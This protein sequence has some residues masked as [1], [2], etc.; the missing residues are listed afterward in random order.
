M[1]S[2]EQIKAAISLLPEG[3]FLV[4]TSWIEVYEQDRRRRLPSALSP[5]VYERYP[6]YR[7]LPTDYRAEDFQKPNQINRFPA[8]SLSFTYGGS[9]TL[10]SVRKME[11]SGSITNLT[12]DN[13]GK[14][15]DSCTPV[16]PAWEKPKGEGKI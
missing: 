10:E 15:V 3:D 8:V 4:L 2:V 11:P 12:Y 6:N 14:R 13:S 9:S 7:Y 5:D 1:Y 16:P